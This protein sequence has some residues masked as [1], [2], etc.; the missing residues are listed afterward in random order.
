M[1]KK[2]KDNDIKDKGKYRNRL[3]HMT[4]GSIIAV[5]VLSIIF[6]LIVSNIIGNEMKIQIQNFYTIVLSIAC[7]IVA[8]CICTY[9][10]DGKNKLDKEEFEESIIKKITDI[11]N[12]KNDL[13]PSYVYPSSDYPQEEFNEYLD[14]KIAESE[15][16]VFYGESARFTCKRLYKIGQKGGKT[17]NLKI[18]IFLINP[19][20]KDLF[21][22][23]RYFLDTIKQ[24]NRNA[25]EKDFQ[26]II[27]DEK[28]KI[29]GCMYSLTKMKSKF[30]S[31]KIYLID[32]MP[33]IDIEMTK[34][35]NMLALEFF[36]T[37][38][39]YKKYPC[40]IIYEGKNLYYDCYKFYIGMERGRAKEM[41]IESLTVDRIIEIGNEAGIKNLS[42][43][44]LK[45]Y[46]D[47]EIVK[48]SERYI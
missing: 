45:D 2:Q 42:E 35:N 34:D 33:F 12:K 25:E 3:L 19:A 4:Y 1:A 7:S 8:T 48:E 21:E 40:T 27:I 28:M 15:K 29:L 46:W 30:L 47:K 36:R 44:M 10:M 22:K 17:N 37:P 41:T 43:D 6:M 38:E 13:T 31:I 20:N 24:R 26:Q 32:N 18:D 11:Y 39:N 14:A 16:F 9:I 5:L 23:N